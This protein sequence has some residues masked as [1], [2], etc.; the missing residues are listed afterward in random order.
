[1]SYK[2]NQ[3]FEVRK[4]ESCLEAKKL[5][6]G[7][8]GLKIISINKANTYKYSNSINVCHAL[9]TTDITICWYSYSN[10]NHSVTTV[11]EVK[12]VSTQTSIKAFECGAH[13]SYI[14]LSVKRGH[15]HALQISWE[16]P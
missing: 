10:H 16:T 14:K 5:N 13:S 3:T 8:L 7:C 12:H 11:C 4:R 15:R 6:L 9:S 1:M 2:D